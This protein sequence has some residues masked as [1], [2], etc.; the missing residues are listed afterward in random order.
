MTKMLFLPG[1]G[2]SAAFWRS[3][4]DRLEPA[5]ARHF[6]AWPGLGDEPH[7]PN[8][9]GMDDLVGMVLAKLDEPADL[10]A[11]SLGGFVALRAA[12]ARPGRI[13]RLVLAATSAGIPMHDYGATDW[14]A[15]YRREFPNAAAWITE[16]VKSREDVSSQLRSVRAPSLLLWGDADRISP[17]AIGH[18]LHQLLPNAELHIVRGGDHDLALTHAAGI[19]P[20]IAEHLR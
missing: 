3:V 5:R 17:P 4:A 18:R 14:R 9:Q 7:D 6:F 12:L 13:R 16:D 8:V 20:M 1:A 2:A 15:D 10:I 19:A 11:Q